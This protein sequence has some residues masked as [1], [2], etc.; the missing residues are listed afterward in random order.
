MAGH[1]QL[2]FVM[3]ECSKTQ[4]R[5]TRPKYPPY[6]FHCSATDLS[7]QK[8]RNITVVSVSRHGQWSAIDIE[9]TNE[10]GNLVTMKSTSVL[11]RQPCCVTITVLQYCLAKA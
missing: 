9:T 10:T 11:V 8:L 7:V 2:K 3:T 1:A 6:L 4:I 5:L